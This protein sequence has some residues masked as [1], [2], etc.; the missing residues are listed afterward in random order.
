MPIA[1]REA[2]VQP[3]PPEFYFSKFESRTPPPLVPFSAAREMLWQFLAAATVILGARYITWRWT[4]SLNH[5]ALW[6]AV[7]T[8]VAETASFIGL[9]LFIV[10]LWRTKDPEQ[11]PPPQW[12]T[13]C[14]VESGFG[15]RP[16]SVDV[17]FPTY[18]EDPELVRLS[19][20]D[21]KRITYPH[22][23]DLRIHVLDDG[24]R[25]EMRAVAEQEGVG[26]ITRSS[27]IG[28]KAGNMR[29]G[30]EHTG[31]DFL[32]ICDADTR[33]YPT[34][35][36][37]TLGYFRDPDVAWVQTPQWFFD[38]PQGTSLPSVLGRYL[39]SVGRRVGCAAEWLVGPISVG[40]DI[41]GSDPSVF[42]DAILRRRNWA[43]ASF[44]CGAGSL[45][46]RE[47]VMEV[48]LRNYSQS[49]ERTVDSLTR[50]LKI[51]DNEKDLHQAIS[52]QL[53][54]ECEVTPYKFHVSEDIYTSIVL[55]SDRTRTWKSV[56]HP[57]VESKMLSPQDLLTVFTQRFKYAGGTLDIAF[58]DNPIFRRGLSWKQ[59]L[60][61]GST[62]WSYLACLW[63][64][65]FLIA[66]LIYFFTGV[67]PVTA[68][69]FDFYSHV[70]PFLLCNEVAMMI[71]L[72][73]LPNWRG[74]SQFLALAPLN[75]KALFTVVRGKKIG[76]A[77]TSKMRQ[78]GTFLG[79]V[80]WQLG[81]V[82]IS[83]VAIVYSGVRLWMGA[84]ASPGA[85]LVN[86]FW[87]L[88]NLVSVA[89]IVLASCWSP[90][91]D[92]SEESQ[93]M[94]E[95]K[96]G[97]WKRSNGYLN[98]RSYLMVLIAM[99]SC[100][101]IVF[102][103]NA[104]EPTSKVEALSPDPSI[105]IPAP[106]PADL[107]PQEKKWAQVA[108]KYF[109]NNYQEKTGLVNSADKYP[110]ATMWDTGSYL[111]AVISARRL[112]LIAEDE[113][114]TRLSRALDAL[115]R[116]PL[117]DGELP[118][119][120]YNTSTLEMVDYNNKSTPRGIGWSAIDIGRLL[121]PFNVI[122]WQY[123]AHTAEVRKVLDHWKMASLVKDGQLF[124]SA[125]DSSGK[126]LYM[127]EGRLGYE[128]YSAK[129]FALI[130]M[131]VSTA[132]HY[133]NFLH[134][135]E[136]DGIQ[137]PTDLRSPEKYHAHNYVVSE[138]YVLDGIEFGGDSF[139]REFAYRVYRAQEER[140]KRTRILT[141]VSE[142]NIDQAPYFVY[143]TVFTNGKA[144]NTITDKGEDASRFKSLSTKAAFGWYALYGTDYANQLRQAVRDAYDPERGWYAGV[145]EST[146]Q[147][148]RAITANTNAVVLES[149]CYRR[150][151]QLVR[152]R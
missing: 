102:A 144:W 104:F 56:Y 6:F 15:Q 121:V 149:L 82:A 55:H 130:A 99:A 127:Q 71:G 20:L 14:V 23:L 29:N 136:I 64:P 140:Y 134:Y 59:K 90:Q 33:P 125:V 79:L 53:A 91:E 52:R 11:K 62:F 10:N 86:A 113:F 37:H 51:P 48:A 148:N 117:Y 95:N 42:Y 106:G 78:T 88:N 9:I 119:K 137:V 18:N 107:Q 143:N 72:W 83:L 17:F 94:D 116:C 77:V 84:T 142:D 112:E 28:F 145:Y 147:P 108:W 21:A 8:A 97:S 131:D 12:I 101:S 63:I 36:E 32:L 111:M 81:F 74:R 96:S 128:Q 26:Y 68:Y 89:G 141:A 65:V 22:P 66:P 150:F 19:I 41:F 40:K 60:M 25:A 24:Q 122:T 2:E 34:I 1:T 49:V 120:S 46:R 39:G 27:N 70:L 67:P 80:N 58:H 138:P 4:S 151:G 44:C 7:P 30:M 129:S 50:D 105:N 132:L 57:S 35:L 114:N 47:A 5:H 16:V 126:T 115:A 103:L 146:A 43:N 87:A 100:F 110:A 31:G 73:G 54:L 3:Q 61:Y 75:L 76:F 13:D 109:E 139:S 38:L 98:A 123:P 69:S 85:W 124:G 118:N 45:H 152:I 93:M 135:V 92:T 133:Q